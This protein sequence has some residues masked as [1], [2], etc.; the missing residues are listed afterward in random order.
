MS[1]NSPFINLTLNSSPVFL[2]LKHEL[3]EHRRTGKSEKT[4]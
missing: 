1:E 2:S 4:S 3:G